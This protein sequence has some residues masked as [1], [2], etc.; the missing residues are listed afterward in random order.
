[1][2]WKKTVQ[3]TE[4]DDESVVNPDELIV[5]KKSGTG[6]RMSVIK[7]DLTDLLDLQQDKNVWIY[8]SNIF[9]TVSPSSEGSTWKP[10]TT[11]I[12]RL[13]VPWSEVSTNVGQLTSEQNIDE[14]SGNFKEL[15]TE[16]NRNIKMKTDFVDTIH[17]WISPYNKRENEEYYGLALVSQYVDDSDERTDAMDIRYYGFDNVTDEYMQPWVDVCF[18]R[19]PI[20]ECEDGDYD[21]K[22]VEVVS[23]VV[24]VEGEDEG[25]T[26]ETLT[27]GRDNDGKVY[28][29]VLKFDLSDYEKKFK[30]YDVMEAFIHLN[31]LGPSGEGPA[32]TTTVKV[33]K[34]TKPWTEDDISW[35]TLEYD[36]TPSGELTIEESR[37]GG[38]EVT[39]PIHDLARNWIDNGADDNYG[40]V[41]IDTDEE[42]NGATPNY[43]HDDTKKYQYKPSLTIC[44]R[45]PESTSS[46]TPVVTTTVPTTEGIATQTTPLITQAGKCEVRKKEP[47]TKM[48]VY[49]VNG[50][51]VVDPDDHDP[52][53]VTLC[54]SE[55]EIDIRYCWDMHGKCKKQQKRDIKG[56]IETNC[57]CCLPKMK[58]PETHT[59]NCEGDVVPRD[60]EIRLIQSCNCKACDG[61]EMK[62]IEPNEVIDRRSSLLQLL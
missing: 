48:T 15:T 13:A 30:N 12:H 36:E 16:P 3:F 54:V 28:R 51:T 6:L 61:D 55:N 11:H 38:T 9:L 20:E 31:Y 22:P 52:E 33:H 41:L 4:G 7:F 53:D 45:R 50:T 62:I 56:K 49:V 24:L 23:T 19:V 25:K 29:T 57:N 34:I 40:V 58:K 26:N 14:S 5:G 10:Q 35:D 43:A 42:T 46:S 47:S 59:F 17:K 44:Q 32:E 37:L 21:K 1:M 2:L 8:E 18:K 27:H 60:I 39:I